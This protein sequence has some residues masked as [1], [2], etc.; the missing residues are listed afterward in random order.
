MCMVNSK[1]SR[2]ELKGMC[3]NPHP[4][5]STQ[6][7]NRRSRS[8]EKAE[9]IGKEQKPRTTILQNSKERSAQNNAQC[10]TVGEDCVIASIGSTRRNL[11]FLLCLGLLVFVAFIFLTSFLVFVCF[12]FGSFLVLMFAH[13]VCQRCY[14]WRHAGRGWCSTQCGNRRPSF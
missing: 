1:S 13:S 9:A 12:I 4:K 7:A 8:S 2:A 14:R 3:T 10:I 6:C 5:V 11:L